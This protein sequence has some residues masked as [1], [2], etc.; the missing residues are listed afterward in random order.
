[1]TAAKG[2]ASATPGH[3]STS[4]CLL[5]AR[6]ISVRFGGIVA[7]DQ[8]TIE[9]PS[10]AVVGLMGPNGAGKSTLLGV[11]SGLLRPR[12]G[13]VRL[14]GQDVTHMSAHRRARAGMARTFQHPA[15]FGPL[16]VR[17]HL[18][19]AYRA[20]H[21]RRRFWLDCV[22]PG[23]LIP[24]SADEVTEIDGILASLGLDEVA[25]RSV[26]ELPLGIHRLVEIGRALATN[27]RIILLDEPGSGLHA[28]ERERICRV[29]PALVRREGTALVLVEHDVDM[30]MRL[31]DT[32]CVLDFGHCIATGTPDEVR[33]DPAVQAA[34]LGEKAPT[35][36]A[37]HG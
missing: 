33:R 1:M 11:L 18:V 22:T 12:T 29:L 5:E 2:L 21:A 36:G 35:T 13:S 8:V 4:V 25:S 23:S 27:P 34:Y 28:G 32:I 7:L 30:I 9:V 16:T 3:D 17:E 19:V 14:D 37:G 26:L 10:G 31:A 15:V 24:A 20:R 6:D